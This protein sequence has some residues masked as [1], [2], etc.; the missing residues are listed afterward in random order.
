MS[1]C[2]SALVD[3]L[4]HYFLTYKEP[5]GAAE[6]RVEITH[7]YNRQE[8]YEVIQRSQEDYKEQYGDL[9]GML[10]AALPG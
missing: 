5:P 10:A 4:R 9:E 3:R 1:D 6:H 8:A 7:V 2:P